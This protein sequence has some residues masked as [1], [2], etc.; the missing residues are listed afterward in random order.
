MEGKAVSAAEAL[1]AARAA[2]VRLEID[3]DDL[4]LEAS[5]PPPAAMLDAVAHHKAE[6]VSLLRPTRDGWL[7]EDRQTLFD[8]RAGIIEYDGGAPRTWAEALARLDP[9][10]PPC[11]TPPKRWLQFVDDCGRFI[12]DGWAACAERL[13]W[14]PLDLFGCNRTK[15]F[16]RLNQAGLLWLLDGRKLH[17]LAGDAAVIATPSGGTLKYRR[18]P[19]EPGRLLAWE[20]ST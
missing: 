4:V 17:G 14:T 3:G 15:P 10:R 18:C 20:A 7:A 11:D 19:D 1:K 6:I 5:L 16:A 9:A 8:E 12:D 2:G 13:G